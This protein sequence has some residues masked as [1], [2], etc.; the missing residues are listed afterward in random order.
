MLET[1][2]PRRTGSVFAGSLVVICMQ[3]A[4]AQTTGSIEGTVTDSSQ[5]AVPNVTVIVTN[6]A[7]RVKTATTTNGTGYF[8]V[9]NMPVGVYDI[10]VNHAGFKT[11]SLQGV[12]LDIA[13]R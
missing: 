7:T 8:R 1:V 5:A 13:A 6:Q 3:I 11:Y 10:S 12:K 2:R 9:E 4:S